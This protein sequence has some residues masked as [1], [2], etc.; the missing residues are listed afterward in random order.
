[1]NRRQTQVGFLSACFVLCDCILNLINN[2][3]FRKKLQVFMEVALVC[4]GLTGIDGYH[5]LHE[6][7]DVGFG[8][9]GA[10]DGSLQKFVQMGV[11]YEAER[12]EH[13]AIFRVAWA[14]E[15]FVLEKQL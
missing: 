2:I 6:A 11:V 4:D 7:S 14:V 12:G 15:G 1:M 13:F 5:Y 9:W 3:T 10:G 8:T